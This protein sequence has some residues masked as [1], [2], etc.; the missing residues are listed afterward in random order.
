MK[1]I[2]LTNGLFAL[3]D[4]IDYYKLLKYKWTAVSFNN[5]KFFARNQKHGLLHKFLLR[6]NPNEIFNVTFKNGDTLDCRRENIIKTESKMLNHGIQLIKK[7]S[8]LGLFNNNNS[9]DEKAG[10]LISENASGVKEKIV[11][12]AKYVSPEGRVFNFGTFET[13]EEAQN[14]YDKMVKMIPR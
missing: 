12:E 14:T 13:K 4:E 5:G 10:N 3:V 1:Q 2:P 11:F 8:Q 6:E 9:V 7:D